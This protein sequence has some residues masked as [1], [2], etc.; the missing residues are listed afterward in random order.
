MPLTP[1]YIRDDGGPL[2][3][4]PTKI[5]PV[6]PIEDHN[7]DEDSIFPNYDQ[8]LPSSSPDPHQPLSPS[9]PTSTTKPTP[10]ISKGIETPPHLR[11]RLSGTQTPLTNTQY[12]Q[13]IQLSLFHAQRT[14]AYAE[15]EILRAYRLAPGNVTKAG[16]QRKAAEIWRLRVEADRA[17]EGGGG[18]AGSEE[19]QEG[20]GREAKSAA[21]VSRR[22]MSLRRLLPGRK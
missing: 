11:P 3:S 1:S 14:G 22:R 10:S 2:E 4:C 16:E 19:K 17:R 13:M 8:A 9:H 20:V 15:E 18:V 21:A 5:P 12:A 7:D 6:H